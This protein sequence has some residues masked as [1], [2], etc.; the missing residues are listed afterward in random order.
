VLEVLLAEAPPPA[1]PLLPD[2]PGPPPGGEPPLVL[3]PPEALDVRP[4]ETP[5]EVPLDASEEPLVPLPT[6]LDPER[7]VL[8]PHAASATHSNA[9]QLATNRM[10]TS[11]WD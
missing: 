2:E 5:A 1:V 7:V 9:T 4:A 6:P 3:E 10:T 8:P 11:K